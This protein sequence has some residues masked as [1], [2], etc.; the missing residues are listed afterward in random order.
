MELHSRTQLEGPG[1]SIAGDLFT[2]DHLTL[3]L[4]LVVHTVQRVPNQLGAVTHHVLRAP[5]WVKVRQVGLGN[6]LQNTRGGLGKRR[7]TNHSSSRQT[8]ASCALQ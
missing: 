4:Q 8:Q 2:L 1:Q 3:R 6:E 7:C 5:N